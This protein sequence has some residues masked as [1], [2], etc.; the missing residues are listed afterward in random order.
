MKSTQKWRLSSLYLVLYDLAAAF[1]AFFL[2][3]W[4]RFDC[5]YSIIPEEYLSSF[6]RFIPIYA[7]LTFAIYAAFRLYNSIWRFAN[8]SELTRVILA[9]GVLCALH[10]SGTVLLGRFFPRSRIARMPVFYYAVGTVT[11]FLLTVAV[12]FS[13]RFFLMLREAYR[14]PD[15]DT[16]RI[17]LIGA[18]EAGHLVL[19]NLVAERES[20]GRVVAII[21][22]DERKWNLSIDGVPIVGGR[23]NILPA[24]ETYKIDKIYIAIPSASPEQ[25]RDIVSICKESRCELRILPDV[26]RLMDGKVPIL[27][28]MGEVT[29][30]DLLG[31]DPVHVETKDLAALLQGKTVLVTGAGGSIGSELA[32][33]IAS[34]APAHLI[35]LDIYE[36]ST[37]ELEIE[38]RRTYPDLDLS[39]LIGSVRDATRLSHIFSSYRPQIVFH[40]AAHKHVPLME[41]S[42]AEAVKNNVFGT[43]KTAYA[44]MLYGCERFVLISS[45]KAVNPTNVMGATKRICEMT[46]QAFARMIA[47]HRESEIPPPPDDKEN[48]LIMPENF[49][50]HT[51]LVAVR[52]GNVLGSNG[53]VVP[54][55]KRQI[56]EGGPVTVTHPDIVRYFMTI[57]EAVSLVLGAA[58]TAESGTLYVLDMG[59]EVRIDSLARNLIKLAGLRPDVDIKIEYTGLRPG[60]KLYEEKLM[61]E[62]GLRTTANS[63]ILI[64]SPIPF[65]E[66][67]FFSQLRDLCDSSLDD[68]D[69]REALSRI[70]PTYHPEGI[71]APL[72]ERRAG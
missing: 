58:A 21:D 1:A 68:I 44:A 42:P 4:L 7:L 52:F 49:V 25:R 67:T 10:I 70:V 71:P 36:N 50:A 15:D 72:D 62:E 23:D 66:T 61:D 2:A 33:Q 37:Y 45:D 48:A 6:F 16:P 41:D 30:E 43:Y 31:R 53:S 18:G 17:L 24:I 9:T 55:F 39:V 65:D 40:A 57:P 56:E 14:R 13:Y 28:A 5:K 60:E 51:A 54:I 38:L 47:A 8:Y 12:R 27:S 11:Q 69:V 3:L 22:D 20:R 35:L 29:M 26:Y 64:G 59:D 34:C 19:H 32:R 46:I 63:K